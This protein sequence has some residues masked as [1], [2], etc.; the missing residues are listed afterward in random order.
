M[1]QIEIVIYLTK[2]A[3]FSDFIKYILRILDNRC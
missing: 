2:I 3:P 1:I